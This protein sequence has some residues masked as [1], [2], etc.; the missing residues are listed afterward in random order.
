MVSCILRDSQ[1]WTDLPWKKFQKHL[2]GLQTRV[3]KAAQRKD[4]KKVTSL[5][6]LIARSN[7]SRFL[8]IRQITQLNSGKKTPG[9]DGKSSLNFSQRFASCEELEREWNNWKHSELRSVLIPKKDGSKR[10]LKIPTINDRIWQCLA[11]YIIEPAHEA[12]FHA[13]SFGFR[14]GRSAHDAQKILCNNL[15]SRANGINKRVIQIDIEKCFDRIKHESILSRVIAPIGIKLGLFRCLKS[16][17]HLEFPSQGTPQ[18]GVI[19]PLL[20]NIALNGIEEIHHCVRYADDLVFILKPHDNPEEI[21]CNLT[22]FL[23]ERGLAVNKK[24]TTIRSTKDGFNFLGWHF[25]CQ[26]NGKFKS[27]PSSENFKNFKK[28]IKNVINSASI[29]VE[30]KV[31]KMGPIVRGWKN[32]HK[33]CC[34]KKSKFSLWGSMFKAY[35]RFKTKKHTSEQAVSLVKKSFPVVST[36]ENRYVNV[37][38][39][40]SVYDNDVSYWSAR[41]SKLYDNITLSLIH[42]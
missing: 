23:E 41:N 3:Y 35:K 16:G 21:L 30:N 31:Q 27:F 34:M 14:P 13:M 39:G 7:S 25:L 12:S 29:S 28:K 10:T 5:Q 20:S 26:N 33:F 1:H 17:T 8:A 36:S 18:G 22:K 32:Y 37:K 19:S 9:V 42:I 4:Y 6:K 11:K 40:K 24:K 2:F 38:G 15:T